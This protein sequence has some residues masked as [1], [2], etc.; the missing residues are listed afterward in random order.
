[1]RFL[2]LFETCRRGLTKRWW[3]T[4]DLLLPPLLPKKFFCTSSPP[5][6][7][8]MHNVLF[9]PGW[10]MRLLWW[11]STCLLATGWSTPSTRSSELLLRTWKK[12]FLERNIRCK[13]KFT[14]W[15]T[16][17]FSGL[18]HFIVS[19]WNCSSL[20]VALNYQIFSH[21]P[22]QSNNFSI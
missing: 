14:K 12:A 2:K 10:T 1:M 8:I 21:F 17:P 7:P 18:G 13:R 19:V 22:E 15:F 11:T 16:K 5:W 20:T 9:R 3:L 6:G 4:S